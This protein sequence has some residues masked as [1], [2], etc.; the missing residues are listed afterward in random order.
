MSPPFCFSSLGSKGHF[1]PL[2]Y[3]IERV[4]SAMSRTPR[5]GSSTAREMSPSARM[6]A[7]EA[8]IAARDQR[9]QELANPGP[10]SYEPQKKQ[11]IQTSQNAFRSRTPRG[12][13]DHTLRDVTIDLEPGQY[14]PNSNRELAYRAKHSFARSASAGEQ[15][16]GSGSAR[17]MRL[18]ILGGEGRHGQTPDPGHYGPDGGGGKLGMVENASK[19]KSSVFNSASAQR[20]NPASDEA[21]NKPPVGQYNPDDAITRANP[22]DAFC[23]LRSKSSR[24]AVAGA[25]TASGAG[26]RG[27]GPDIG[28]GMHENTLKTIAGDLSSRVKRMTKHTR[29]H[30][31]FGGKWAAHELPHER[32][33]RAA[34]DVPGPG[35][36]E[37]KTSIKDAYNSAHCSAFTSGTK[38]GES[39]MP[40]FKAEPTDPGE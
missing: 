12:K 24:L 10:G 11:H 20:V 22:R 8:K 39:L 29:K 17:R 4:W 15:E 3:S 25:F 7:T 33:A 38:R 30:A 1:G 40:G 27:T 32:L 16:F 21:Q 23:T 9:R 13:P 35:A 18:D 36:Y 2:V 14:E 5:S 19:M 6:R 28:P 34:E 37:A 26:F 31:G